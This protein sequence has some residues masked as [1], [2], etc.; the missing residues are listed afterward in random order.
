V[1]KWCVRVYVETAINA[2]HVSWETYCAV[3][4]LNGWDELWTEAERG[5]WFALAVREFG[6]DVPIDQNIEAAFP[7]ALEGI[8]WVFLGAHG[9]FQPRERVVRYAV[10]ETKLCHDLDLPEN[11]DPA[12]PNFLDGFGEG[13]KVWIVEQVVRRAPEFGVC[14][15]LGAHLF[16]YLVKDAK[17]DRVFEALVEEI[18]GSRIQELF[19]HSIGLAIGD[20]EEERQPKPSLKTKELKHRLKVR[21]GELFQLLDDGNIK[22]R[23]QFYLQKRIA[24]GQDH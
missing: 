6:T 2:G 8:V 3:V 18:C 14:R 15:D 11:Q 19:E 23:K 13:E 4:G 21:D 5:A 22:V 20:C 9:W 17:D 12:F 7:T 24:R 16:Y 10:S 1:E